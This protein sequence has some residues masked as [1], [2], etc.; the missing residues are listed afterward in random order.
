MKQKKAKTNYTPDLCFAFV[1]ITNRLDPLEK[2]FYKLGLRVSSGF[3]N[4]PPPP[5][6]FIS[7]LVF[8]NPDETIA[9]VY[10]A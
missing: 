1:F 8:R 6:S 2:P 7:F 3:L 9:F 4:P 10:K 5:R